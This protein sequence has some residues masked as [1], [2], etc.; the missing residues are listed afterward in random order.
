MMAMPNWNL[1]A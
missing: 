1:V